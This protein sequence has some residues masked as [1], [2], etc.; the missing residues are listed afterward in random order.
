MSHSINTLHL[1]HNQILCHNL[2]PP[3]IYTETI[4]KSHM[5]KFLPFYWLF[6]SCQSPSRVYMTCILL[7]RKNKLS[8]YQKIFRKHAQKQAVS[9]KKTYLHMFAKLK[10]H[11]LH[12]AHCHQTYI[13]VNTKSFTLYNCHSYKLQRYNFSAL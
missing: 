2:F 11:T 13:T 4:L 9:R 7:L 5:A 1:L 3:Y 12:I 6:I 8:K 10:S